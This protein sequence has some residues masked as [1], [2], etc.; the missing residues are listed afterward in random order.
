MLG[1]PIYL[2]YATLERL[3]QA[4]TVGFIL[5]LIANFVV[6]PSAIRGYAKWEKSQI[7]DAL[8][9]GRFFD[10][11]YQTEVYFKVLFAKINKAMP[12][13]LKSALTL[14][15]LVGAC[16]LVLVSMHIG[17]LIYEMTRA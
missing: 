15:R 11:G 16:L 13:A 12:A 7:A 1:V 8:K 2:S 17:L 5:C 6:V 4:L 10:Q 9:L 14:N 3:H